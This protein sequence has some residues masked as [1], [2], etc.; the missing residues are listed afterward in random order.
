MCFIR[1]AFVV[2][3][4][5]KLSRFKRGVSSNYKIDMGPVKDSKGSLANTKCPYSIPVIVTLEVSRFF[6]HSK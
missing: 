2:T 6:S 3:K 4:L 1:E 5:E